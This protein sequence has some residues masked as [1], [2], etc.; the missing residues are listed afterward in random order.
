MKEDVRHHALS[1]AALAARVSARIRFALMR[2]S[3]TYREERFTC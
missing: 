1:P 3:P 2:F